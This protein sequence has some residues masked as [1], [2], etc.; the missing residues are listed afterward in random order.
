MQGVA[1]VGG[2][3]TRMQPLTFRTPKP[4]LPLAQRPLIWHTIERC[5]AAGIDH[6]VL[7]TGYMPELF[8]RRLGSSCEG[9]RLTY[10]HESESL[11]TAGG[12]KNCEDYLGETFVV[13]NGDVLTS[14]D[15]GPMIEFHQERGAVATI[16]LTEV[17]DP[18][19]YGVVP[20]SATGEVIDFI[21]KP[22]A[23]EAPTNFINGGVYVLERSVL[24]R[25]PTGIA[26]SFEREVFPSLLQ[27]GAPVM[28]YK[29]QCYWLDVGTP[30]KYLQAHEDLLSS[31]LHLQPPGTER[32]GGIFVIG[33]AYISSEAEVIGP[34]VLGEGA[35]IGASV[36]IKGPVSVGPRTRIEG[37]T[38]ITRS[39]FLG[40]NVVGP[41]CR[42]EDAILG[43]ASEI[44]GDCVIGELAVIG[45]SV[46]IKKG[47]EL[48]RGMRI[49]P[50]IV[51]EESA[52]RF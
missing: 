9:V 38:E 10:V 27:E 24:D 19:A 3:G 34:V 12:V 8:E 25:I 36:S 13:F 35:H 2:Q 22:E 14:L 43:E 17:E 47:N 28:G 49:W 21:E 26:C 23:G 50:D 33:D 51:V 7:S 45:A 4:L 44:E 31:K 39:V 29:S 1:L 52:I 48:R 20:T 32:D 37:P 42:I 30:A 16:F 18:S 41:G 46:V 6:L 5:K 15:I 40:D 11:G